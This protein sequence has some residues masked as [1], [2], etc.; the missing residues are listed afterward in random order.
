MIFLLLNLIDMK[1]KV[2]ANMFLGALGLDLVAF[3]TLNA[4]LVQPL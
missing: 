1:K 4:Y 3:I 2:S